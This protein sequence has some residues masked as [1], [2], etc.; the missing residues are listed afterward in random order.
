MTQSAHPSRAVPGFA[1]RAERLLHLGGAKWA[2]HHRAN[3]LAEEGRDVIWLTI[4]EPDVPAPP[5]LVEAT[6]EAM[7]AGRTHYSSGPGETALR[8]ALAKRYTA[9]CGRPITREQVLCFPGTQTA[10]YAVM[11]ILADE[12]AEVLAGDPMYATY[13][14]VVEAAGATLVPVPLRPEQG[15]RLQA[16]DLAQHITPASRAVLLNTP[17]NP[18]GAVL[19]RDELRAIGELAL[20]HGLWIVVD[21]VYEE[22]TFEGAQFHSPLSDP[23]LADRVIVVSSISK[24]HA[25]TGFRSGWSIAPEA[26]SE[27][28]LPLSETMLFGNQPFIADMTVEAIARPSPVA[29]GMRRRFRERAEHLARRTRAGGLLQTLEPEGGMFAM[30]DVSATGLDGEAFAHSLVE[31]TGVAVMPGGSFGET[32]KDW[33]RIALTVEDARFREAVGR[34]CDHA[35]RLVQERAGA[36]Q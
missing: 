29:P 8:D 36:A 2:V 31:E 5:E 7:R 35:E 32:L 12:G 10:L 4:G 16:A 34:L 13:E 28:V 24:S 25:A 15:F 22:L 3:A 9:T 23:D 11:A 27:R 19:R 30:V 1:E 33:V 20:A 26:V 18:T 21:E 6:A 14:G 17:H